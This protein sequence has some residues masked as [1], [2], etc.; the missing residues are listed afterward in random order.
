MSDEL[1]SVVA[2][3]YD[4]RLKL[5]SFGTPYFLDGKKELCTDFNPRKTGWMTCDFHTYDKFQRGIREVYLS[6]PGGF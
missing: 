4:I 3:T 6:F 5:H 2:C 1:S